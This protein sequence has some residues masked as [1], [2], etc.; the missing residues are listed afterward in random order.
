M[1]RGRSPAAHQL[2]RLGLTPQPAR[3]VGVPAVVPR[4]HV[5]LVGNVDQH[6]R[7]EL[8]GVLGFG[9]RGGT[10]RRIGAVG[11]RL[12]APVVRQPLKRHRIPRVVPREPGREGPII[13]GN[14]HRRMHVNSR[15]WPCE[16]AAGFTRPFERRHARSGDGDAG[17]RRHSNRPSGSGLRPGPGAVPYR[18]AALGGSGEEGARGCLTDVPMPRP[19]PGAAA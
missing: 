11:H 13:L 14:P 3:A 5:A 9:A 7:Q 15:M 18:D 2:G 6:P 17:R 16:H 19:S 4:G 8:Q 1:G 10:L 12:R